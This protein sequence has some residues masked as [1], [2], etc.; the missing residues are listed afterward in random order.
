MFGPNSRITL[1]RTGAS[2]G[3]SIFVANHYHNFGDGHGRRFPKPVSLAIAVCAA[4][5]QQSE[6]RCSTED[7][8]DAVQA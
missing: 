8:A 7:D 5:I 6:S 4:A 3:R 2:G 1:M